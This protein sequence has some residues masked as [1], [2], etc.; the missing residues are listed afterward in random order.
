M[1]EGN[2]N[3]NSYTTAREQDEKTVRAFYSDVLSAP[4]ETT[5][6]R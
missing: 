6:E 3:M 4:A 2:P 1:K 5:D